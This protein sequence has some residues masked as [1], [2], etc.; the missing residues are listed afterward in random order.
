[1][2]L[3]GVEAVGGKSPG[4]GEAALAGSKRLSSKFNLVSE[5]AWPTGVDPESAGLEA[6]P[7]GSKLL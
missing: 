2:K 4:I 1:V 3:R 7:A 5:F 6:A